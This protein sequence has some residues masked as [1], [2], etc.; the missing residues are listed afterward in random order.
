[1]LEINTLII[2]DELNAIKTLRWELEN[3]GMPINVVEQ[4]TDIND[5]ISF[6]SDHAHKIDLVFLDIQMPEMDG[7]EFLDKFTIRTFDVIFV[8]AYDEY[9]LQ[10]IKESA[11][12]YIL[13]PVEEEELKLAL[14]K[15]IFKKKSNSTTH[16]ENKKIAIPVENK[17]LFLKPDEIIYCNSDGNYT[18]IHTIHKKIMISKTL[19]FVEELLPKS[20][21]YRIHQSYI[22]NLKNIEAYDRSTNY[23]KL[24]NNIE[25]PVSRSKRTDFLK[26]L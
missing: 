5:A 2:D 20:I 6:L 9:A 10:A 18:N 14:K 16:Q 1:M 8:T 19:K 26:Q 4:F 22:I 7:F 17:F 21:F 13:K 23:V 3:I 24:C 25:L 15:I 11:T 12:D